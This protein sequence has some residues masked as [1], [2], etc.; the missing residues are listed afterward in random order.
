MNESI[1]QKGKRRQKRG[2]KGQTISARRR[3]DR[4][5]RACRRRGEA[6]KRQARRLY[7]FRV[8]VVRMYNRL[9]E[10]ESEKRAAELT[11]A[12]Y[13]P[14]E[15]WHF[16][17]SLS[18]IR[19]WARQAKREGM[20]SLYPKSRRPKTIHY[21]VPEHVVE[22]IYVLR[23]LFGWGGHRIA[24]EL[25]RRA[26]GKVSGQGVY[27]I[28]ERLG[29]P[30]KVYALKGRSEGIAYRR[31]EKKRPNEQ[32]HIDLKHL[33]LTDGTKVYVC[34][35]LDDY[36]RYALAAVAGTQRTTQWVRSVTE[37]TFLRAGH[38][39]QIVSDNGLEFASV[40]E[41]TL[42]AFG[43]LLL[44]Q[45]VEHHTTAPFYPQGN[46]KVEAFI[47]SLN[48]E[49]LERQ[50]FDTLDDLQAALDR[51]LTYS[52]NYRAHSALGWQPPVTRYAGLSMSVQGLAGIPGIEPMASQ[53]RY[54]PAHADPP[55]AI[56]PTTATNSCALA[57][58]L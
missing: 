45:A 30:V 19:G 26:I 46:G 50:S 15:E 12:R 34:V 7:K 56:S 24:A 14:R 39:A 1:N 5:R 44:E 20:T 41:D 37:Q 28:F 11:L 33:K 58:V 23:K 43:H 36:S 13:R 2:S 48:R 51:Y 31:Y 32:W 35:I 57:L 10:Q 38:P 16:A 22:V 9:G 47:R 27:N 17:L 3:A 53:S 54:G 4:A 49:L 29:L 55:V 6:Q 18:T 8:K 21:Q 25:E 40:W 42:T 52:N